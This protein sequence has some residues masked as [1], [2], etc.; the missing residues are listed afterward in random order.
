MLS[1]TGC[2]GPGVVRILSCNFWVRRYSTG[3]TNNERSLS[4]QIYISLTG[5]ASVRRGC[6]WVLTTFLGDFLLR[7][8][9]KIQRKGMELPSLSSKVSN[10]LTN[11]FQ[12]GTDHKIYKNKGVSH[13]GARQLTLI[14]VQCTLK[15]LIWVQG[16]L[17]WVQDTHWGARYTKD[18]HLGARQ[19]NTLLI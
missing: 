10:I 1:Q 8:K 3:L 16:T 17:I 12:T 14:W 13:L 4:A 6:H 7:C 19:D 18:T 2:L 11:N 15:I 5:V 9:N